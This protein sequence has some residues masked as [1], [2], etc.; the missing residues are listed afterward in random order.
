[1]KLHDAITLLRS[2]EKSTKMLGVL[3]L[4]VVVG[5]PE[6]VTLNDGTC[7]LALLNEM[8]MMTISWVNGV[9]WLQSIHQHIHMTSPDF[10]QKNY[11]QLCMS[12]HNKRT[13]IIST[14]KVR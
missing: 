8:R 3:L 2:I 1:M 14:H 13:Q 6:S 7:I 9:S 4:D 12:I 10:L 5:F 11:V